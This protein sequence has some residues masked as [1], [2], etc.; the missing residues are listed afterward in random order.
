MKNSIINLVAEAKALNS[1]IFSLPRILILVSL[2]DLNEDGS[3]YRELK[4]GLDLEDGILFSNLN[5]LEEM[6]YIQSKDVTVEKKKMTSYAITKEGKETLQA[7]R[8][9]FRKIL[10]G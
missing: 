9:W 7:L 1:K 8:S 2:E 10:D 6:G 5:A 3:S 4:A